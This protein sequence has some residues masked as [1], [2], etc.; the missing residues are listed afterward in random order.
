MYSGQK[1]YLKYN[2][3]HN[4]YFFAKSLSHNS[5]SIEFKPIPNKTIMLSNQIL[6]LML[7]VIFCAYA[8]E[9]EQYPESLLHPTNQ[10]EIDTRRNE[11]LHFMHKHFTVLHRTNPVVRSVF[12]VYNEFVETYYCM[13]SNRIF[14]PYMSQKSKH[15]STKVCEFLIKIFQYVSKVSPSFRFEVKKRWNI[16]LYNAI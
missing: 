8:M 13:P 9:N 15:V 11:Q 12:E 4:F 7:C 6:T 3:S 14:V 2:F 1:L 16:F 10:E 5:I